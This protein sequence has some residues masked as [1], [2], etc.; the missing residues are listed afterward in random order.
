MND[1]SL[2]IQ[3]R[4]LHSGRRPSDQRGLVNTPV[5]RGSTIVSETL[6]ELR[7]KTI[8]DR[9][10]GAM[11]YGRFGT[12]TTFALEDAIADLE[13]GHGGLSLPSGLAAVTTSLLAFAK[14]GDHVLVADTV[15]GPTRGFCNRMLTSLQIEVEFY[16]PM[17]GSDIDRICR[18][19]TQC[20]FLE[21]PGSLTFEVQDVPAIVA[22]AKSR[23]IVTIIDNTWATPIFYRPLELGVN[24]S[25]IAAT[26]YVV[27]HADAM[28]GLIVADEE[29]YPIVRSCRDVLGQSV[30]PDDIYLGLRGLRT[31]SVRIKQHE[32]QTLE[33][34]KWLESHEDVIEVF[35]PALTNCPGHEIWKRDFEGSSG[36]FSF[37]LKSKSDDALAA[38]LDPM[39]LF[40]MGYSWG[41]FES[42]IVPANPQATRS[43]TTWSK[44]GQLIRVH[45]GLENVDD[46]KRDLE[47]GIQRYYEY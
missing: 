13:G 24:V 11:I 45:I 3:T 47:Q 29:H 32:H 15:Y 23:N 34:A 43:A 28:L 2:K 14:P 22:V 18:P 5:Y 17:I 37:S 10:I 27:G 30:A 25:V 6:K 16:D 7:S 41:G 8:A 1:K 9:E 42:L 36:L 46:L 12:P 35:H 40:S 39:K 44:P 21:S 38:M 19:N 20:I 4:A 31:L 33:I 26:K